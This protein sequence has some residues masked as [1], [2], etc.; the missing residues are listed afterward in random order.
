VSPS[1][2]RCGTSHGSGAVSDRLLGRRGS[3]DFYEVFVEDVDEFSAVREVPTPS[4]FSVM[5]GISE[6]AFKACLG[7]ILGDATGK[8]WGGE[9]SDHFAAHVHLGG[10]ATTAAFLL[11]E[12]ARFA[13]MGLNHLGKNNDQIFRLA[14]EPAQLLV[15]QHAHE[16]TTPVRGTLRAFAV[17]PGAPRRYCLIDGRDSLRL[18]TAYDKVERAMEL[19]A[20]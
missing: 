3:Y 5:E 4:D 8:D 14:Q 6:S 10:K 1:R 12:P 2:I 16:I 13:P 11:K 9:I 15:V 18:L 19:S 20:S 17:Q 7:E